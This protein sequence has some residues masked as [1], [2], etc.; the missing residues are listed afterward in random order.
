[1]VLRE[2]LSLDLIWFNGRILFLA[3]DGC[4]ERAIYSRASLLKL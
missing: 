2:I 1:M 4:R 3:P